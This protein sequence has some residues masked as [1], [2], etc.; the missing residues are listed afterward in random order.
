MSKVKEFHKTVVL[1]NKIRLFKDRTC[2]TVNLISYSKKM[3]N[4]IF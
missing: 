4:Y 1:H 3:F 2:K